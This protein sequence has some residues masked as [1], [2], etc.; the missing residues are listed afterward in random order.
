MSRV[1][2]TTLLAYNSINYSIKLVSNRLN[3]NV[4]IV[5]KLTVWD[6]TQKYELIGGKMWYTNREGLKYT[7]LRSVNRLKIEASSPNY[8]ITMFIGDNFSVTILD[9]KHTIQY[10]NV[11]KSIMLVEGYDIVTDTPANFSNVYEALAILYSLFS[12]LNQS[13]SNQSN[14]D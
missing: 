8:I 14:S 13:T 11:D 2:I 4:M 3:K 10:S 5:N 7:S 9:N 6:K 12:K 1:G